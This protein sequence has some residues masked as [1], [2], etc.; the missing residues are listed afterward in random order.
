MEKTILVFVTFLSFMIYGCS[1]DSENDL[2][3]P[4]VNPTDNGGI[5]NYSNNVKPIMTS[6]CISC[7]ASPPINGAPFSL[8]TYDQVSQRANNVLNAMSRQSGASG[9]MPPAGRLPQSTID[10]IQ[11]W[12]DDGLPEN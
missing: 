8:I 12:I 2:I 11:Q 3:E 4:I 10:I 7:H 6:S 9:A 5:V 1:Y